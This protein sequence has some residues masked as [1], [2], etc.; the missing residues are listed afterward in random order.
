MC[1]LTSV[2]EQANV[3]NWTHFFFFCFLGPHPQH[4]EVS[5]LEV[6][7]EL[8]LLAYTTATATSDLSCICYLHHSSW[9][10]RSLTH[11]T[12]PG[13]EPETSW[14]LVRFVCTVPQRELLQLT[15]K[16]IKTLMDDGW[17]SSYSS[18]A[19]ISTVTGPQWWVCMSI[20]NPLTFL[21]IWKCS[22]W[23]VSQEKYGSKK[24]E[25]K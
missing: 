20:V 22:W 8:Q 4:M 15:L 6:P 2:E 16:C 21:G 24:K 23:N 9:Q 19:E 11:W 13:I 18:V 3:C 14:F 5:R 25:T 1:L 7:L 17:R 12:K 10:P